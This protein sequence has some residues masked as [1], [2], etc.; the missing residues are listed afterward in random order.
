MAFDPGM[1]V[2]PLG[3]RDRGRGSTGSGHWPFVDDPVERG[4]RHRAVRRAVRA[5]SGVEGQVVTQ[6]RR[7]VVPRIKTVTPLVGWTYWAV[8]VL[9]TP[10]AAVLLW[11]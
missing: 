8:F 10:L 11:H 2:A 6:P 3:A 9:G 5:P 1:E 4:P 7:I